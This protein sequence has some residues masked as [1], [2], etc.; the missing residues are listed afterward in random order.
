MDGSFQW[1]MGAIFFLVSCAMKNDARYGWTV[2]S[3]GENVRTVGGWI[4]SFV[5]KH[6]RACVVRI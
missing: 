5:F 2:A 3:E 6:S 4:W 1:M